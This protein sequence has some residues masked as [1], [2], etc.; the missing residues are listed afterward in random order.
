M[1][2]LHMD[3]HL[4]D[5]FTRLTGLPECFT[6]PLDNEISARYLKWVLSK[7]KRESK[8]NTYNIYIYI[9]NLT[10]PKYISVNTYQVFDPSNKE[11]LEEATYIAIYKKSII[12]YIYIYIYIYSFRDEES[13]L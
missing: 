8:G 11:H 10:N 7:A 2:F 6:I 4:I 9:D 5:I 3:G 12:H 1:V 13:A